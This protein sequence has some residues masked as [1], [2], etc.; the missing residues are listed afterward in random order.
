MKEDGLPGRYLEVN[1]TLCRWLDYTREELLALS[2][3]DISEQTD[4]AVNRD[5]AVSFARNRHL[6]IERTL[7]AKNGRKIPVE[8]NFHCITYEGKETALSISRDIS[9]RR[10][11][12]AA[13]RE[14][15]EEFRTTIE[16]CLEGVSIIDENGIVLVWNRALE[17]I[18]G[19]SA[20]AAIGR[21]LWNVQEM[22]RLP[23]ERT[24]D[25]LE[26]SKANVLHALQHADSSFTGRLH[27]ALIYK[28]DGTPVNIQ[29]TIF[30]IKTGLGMRLGSVL[31]DMTL[32]KKAQQALAR[33][34]ELY[35]ALV[36]TT[37]TAY[38]VI[39]DSGS[40]LDANADFR[41]RSVGRGTGENRSR[42]DLRGRQREKQKGDCA[43][44]ARRTDRW[45]RG[46]V[47]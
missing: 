43:M 11:A 47:R 4:D 17:S 6:V 41:S 20:G 24:A 26:K 40:V 33:S 12:E 14:S 45:L 18:T 9:E 39:D 16:Q 13:L 8:V 27:E 19:V 44:R 1:D 23:G 35:R 46:A 15:E 2:P 3:L 21:P 22:M 34:E 28:P 38:V 30:P 37:G 36:E 5:I 10:A 25:R 42:M 32:Q 31:R 29:Q 7:V